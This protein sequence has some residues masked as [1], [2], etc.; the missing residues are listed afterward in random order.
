ML[1]V[2]NGASAALMLSVGHRVGLFDTMSGV[3]P[4]TPHGRRR[5][6]ASPRATR[7]FGEAGL[8]DIAVHTVDGDP[9]NNSYVCQ[10]PAWARHT[11]AETR[12][13]LAERALG[14]VDTAVLI[15]RRGQGR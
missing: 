8:T 9:F 11:A 3:A 7:A 10:K 2:L 6:S 14:A 12:N 13:D 15:G 4:A 5:R 1:G